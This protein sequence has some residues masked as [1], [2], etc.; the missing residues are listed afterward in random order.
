MNANS[1][2]TAYESEQ[3]YF[4]LGFVYIA[5]GITWAVFCFQNRGDILPLQHYVSGTIAFLIIEM[6]AISGYYSYLNTNGVRGFAR[7]LLV[8]GEI[9][10]FLLPAPLR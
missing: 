3:F 9:I 2:R 10:Y 8:L 1:R 6:F 7:P 4:L 5:I